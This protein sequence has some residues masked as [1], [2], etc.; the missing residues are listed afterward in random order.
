MKIVIDISKMNKLSSKRGIGIY[1]QML[2]KYL[3]QLSQ[4]R[5]DF[6]VKLHKGGRLDYDR[7]NL[8]HYPFF[9]FYFNTL[10]YSHLNKVVITLHDV[11]PLRFKQ[12]YPPGI[13]GQLR[14]Y[15]QKFKLGQVKGIITDSYSSKR[16]IIKFLHFKRNRIYPVYLAGRILPSV[17]AGIIDKVKQKYKLFDNFIFY[18]GDVNYHKNLK[19]LIKSL[20]YLNPRT[21]LVLA[22]SGFTHMSEENI[23]LHQAIHFWK[24]SK[25][26][27]MLGYLNSKELAVLYQ[28]ADFY[29]Q[30]SLWEGFGL[31]VIEAL[32]Q[33]T[34]VIV[35]N[36]SSLREIVT[37]EVATF[38][39]Y[40][41]NSK[42]I[43]EAIIQAY[44][45]KKEV[46]R[47]KLKTYSAK[48]N[49]LRTAEET[50]KVYRLIYT[51]GV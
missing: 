2:F 16:D 33:G 41:F 21:K 3:R 51:S 18:L 32:S 50:Y 34:P 13:R 39:K 8:I 38:I 9:D 36:N 12:Y 47:E 15:W 44:R 29:I 43:A 17:E 11:I 27:K 1:A 28:L 40:P 5:G 45:R 49:W 20:K 10:P 42:R 22:G 23:Q 4:Q 25:R 24:L 6:E 7:Y 31:P 19:A 30:P 37:P 14:F 46:E 35:S 48:F 26:V